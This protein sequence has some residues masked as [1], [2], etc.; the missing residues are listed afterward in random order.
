MF[1]PIE[2]RD[3]LNTFLSSKGLKQFAISETVKFG[4]ITY[5]FNGNSYDKANGE[6][7]IRI[8]S[9]TEPFE[10]RPWMR[11]AEITDA[12]VTKMKNFIIEIYEKKR[13]MHLK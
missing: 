3:T 12:A 2:I 6:E 8:N 9:Y 1:E 7:F 13:F 4:H 10:T 11:T 5:Y